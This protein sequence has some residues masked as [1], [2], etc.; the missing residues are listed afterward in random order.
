MGHYEHSARGLKAKHNTSGHSKMNNASAHKPAYRTLLFYLNYK[1]IM[2]LPSDTN[3]RGPK[4]L[5]ETRKTLIEKQQ[6]HSTR[7][8]TE[9]CARICHTP[10]Q[11]THVPPMNQ[12]VE[13]PAHM[14]LEIF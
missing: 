4:M 13:V 14:A 1:S 3:I 9:N 7:D 2:A 11:H 8:T 6:H 5:R 10:P 12:S